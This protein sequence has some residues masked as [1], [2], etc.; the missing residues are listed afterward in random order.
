[1]KRKKQWFAV[2][3]AALLAVGQGIVSAA[4]AER[5]E[6]AVT[7]E[8]D[9]SASQE[10]TEAQTEEESGSAPAAASEKKQETTE[11]QGVKETKVSQEIGGGYFQ[12]KEIIPLRC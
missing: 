3:L 9:G 2:I 8:A 11:K 5:T 6:E 4:P 1:M 12:K 7:A 10:K